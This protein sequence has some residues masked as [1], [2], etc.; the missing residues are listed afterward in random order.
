MLPSS[1]NLQKTRLHQD[2]FFGLIDNYNF[3]K[4]TP[5]VFFC[6]WECYSAIQKAKLSE[7]LGRLLMRRDHVFVAYFVKSKGV[8][9]LDICLRQA[10]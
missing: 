4:S 6:F 10:I 5:C 7:R 1:V 3:K 2:R 8:F 9:C